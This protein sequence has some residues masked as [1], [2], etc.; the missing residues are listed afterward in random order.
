MRAG[1]PSRGGWSVR[2]GTVL[3]A[4]VEYTAEGSDQV[5]D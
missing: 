4:L 2:L 1:G 3:E 5:E